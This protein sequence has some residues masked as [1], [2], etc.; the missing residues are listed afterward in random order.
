[1][2][3]SR[4]GILAPGIR[5]RPEKRAIVTPVNGETWQVMRLSRNRNW[6]HP[7]LVEFLERLADQA[8]K[9]GWHGS[10][11]AELPA[12]CRQVLMAP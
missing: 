6:G 2:F 8:P 3:S 1:M 4:T 7:S 9:T 10:K 5:R 12:A 11:M